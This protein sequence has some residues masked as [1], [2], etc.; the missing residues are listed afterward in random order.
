MIPL[1]FIRSKAF[2]VLV[3][4][5]T[6]SAVSLA[7]PRQDEGRKYYFALI[8]KDGHTIE[9]WNGGDSEFQKGGVDRLYVEKDGKRYLITDPETIKQIRTAFAPVLKIAN[10]QA[11]L[12]ERQAR[13]GDKQA[14]IG[15]KQAALGEK[16]GKLGEQ[17]GDVAGS[18]DPDSEAKS[19]DIHAQMD[20]LQEQMKGLDRQMDEPSG[21]QKEL[22]KQQK[23]LGKQEKEADAKARVKIDAILDSAFSRG[24]AK[25][26]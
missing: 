25:P 8:G 24:L 16:L 22:G 5:L 10:Q 6:L 3:A 19:K 1:A 2:V 7:S 17:L 18:N 20:A 11:A 21:Q 26:E 4:A 9:D 15:E 13:L 23:A 12:G 14:K